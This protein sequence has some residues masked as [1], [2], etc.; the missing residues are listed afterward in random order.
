MPISVAIVL[1][2]AKLP[3]H[4]ALL[5]CGGPLMLIGILI[6]IRDALVAAALAWVGVTLETRAMDEPQ[7]ACATQQCAQAAR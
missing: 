4:N 1:A 3:A 7:P 5:L 6:A 2:P